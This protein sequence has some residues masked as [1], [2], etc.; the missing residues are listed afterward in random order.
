MYLLGHAVVE[1]RY[2][3]K[4]FVEPREV[5]QQLHSATRHLVELVVAKRLCKVV[6]LDIVLA[7]FL[8]NF[9]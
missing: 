7:Q 5:G 4:T 2:W 1:R 6:F 8:V 9:A 3:H